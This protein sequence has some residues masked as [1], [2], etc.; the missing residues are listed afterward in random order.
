MVARADTFDIF[1]SADLSIVKLSKLSAM[2]LA[3]EVGGEVHRFPTLLKAL[4]GIVLYF[5]RIPEDGP[6]APT[7]DVLATQKENRELL[8]SSG[9]SRCRQEC[10]FV[11]SLSHGDCSGSCHSGP[12]ASDWKRLDLR[13][14]I[15]RKT[16]ISEG[17]HIRS[18]LFRWRWHPLSSVVQQD[19]KE[20]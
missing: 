20:K 16:R 19:R 6:N 8:T 17:S 7:F 4:S 1:N 14:L 3:L 9:P 2:A 18:C 12:G 10:A 11:S 15:N 5:C 13:E